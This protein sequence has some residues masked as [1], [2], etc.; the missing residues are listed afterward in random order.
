MVVIAGAKTFSEEGNEKEVMAHLPIS[1]EA[2]LCRSCGGRRVFIGKEGSRRLRC[3]VCDRDGSNG[4]STTHWTV[5]DL[6]FLQGVG[7]DTD[8]L[9]AERVAAYHQ[10][11]MHRD[12]SAC[13]YCGAKTWEQHDYNCARAA[14]DN[15]LAQNQSAITGI[16]ELTF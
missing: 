8:P 7:I 15:P 5:G 3:P 11:N 2:W 16:T 12:F 14:V 10:E 6:I 4:E 9:I 1:A 13:H